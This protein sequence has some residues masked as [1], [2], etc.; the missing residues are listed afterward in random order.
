MRDS[1]RQLLRQRV[2]IENLVAREVKARYRG[3]LLGFIWSFLNPLLMI[4][5]YSLVFSVFLRFRVEHYAIFVFCGL[6]PWIWFSSSLAEGIPS[7]VTGSTMLTRVVFHAAVLPTV[8]VSSN[9]VNF[10]LSLPLLV[11]FLVATGFPIGFPLVALPAL[12][13]LQFFF[14]LGLVLLLSALNVFYRD[15]Q[16]L[17]GNLLTLGF[18]LCPI[19]YPLHLVPERFRG[20][21]YL[22]PMGLLVK[23]YQ[24]VFY[25]YR[26]PEPDAFLVMGAFALGSL[27]IGFGVFDRY[28]HVFAEE[29]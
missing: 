2:L 6:L 8:R 3:S 11:I 7:I 27:V 26:L 19:I 25:H 20:L 16:H 12:I 15:V 5:V 29:I 9:L 28:R 17:V 13:V 24:D 4:L 23:G 14:T 22:N 1:I 18:F 21:L 10:L